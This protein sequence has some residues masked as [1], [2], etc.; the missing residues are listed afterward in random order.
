MTTMSLAGCA[1]A[2]DDD[3]PGD[4]AADVATDESAQAVGLE[5][6]SGSPA[7]LVAS[8]KLEGSHVIEFY[9]F[10]GSALIVE[11]AAAYTTPVLDSADPTPDQLV[12]IWRRLAPRTSVP[13]ALQELQHRLTD[14]PPGPPALQVVSPPVL[15]G[16]Q[17]GRSGPAVPTAQVGCNNGCCDASWLSTLAECQGGGFSFSWFLFN[18]VWSGSNGGNNRE[19]QGLVCS[20]VGTSTFSVNIG[21]SGGTWSIPEATLRW[22]HWVAGTDIF[23]N[24]LRRSL[25]SSVNSPSA[26]HLHTYCGRTN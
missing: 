25:A 12:S 24:P 15:G 22:F 17:I 6:G 9:D 2:T 4:Q 5:P 23:G 3:A 18:Q 14:Q 7:T 10:G 16:D 26:P 19:Y 1:T 13:P 21:G 8:L 20:A 11:T